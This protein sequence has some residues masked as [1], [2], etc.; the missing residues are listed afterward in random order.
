M[1]F[2]VEHHLY[3]LD[4]LLEKSCWI[5]RNTFNGILI[6]FHDR[7]SNNSADLNNK[8]FDERIDH[9]VFLGLVCREM[10]FFLFIFTIKSP[11][12]KLLRN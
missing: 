1:D 7:F 4:R 10:M 2:W 6:G 9:F 8:S 5:E 11:E 3:D 12:S